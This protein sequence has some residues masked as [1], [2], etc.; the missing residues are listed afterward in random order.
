MVFEIKNH[1]IF[2]LLLG[3]ENCAGLGQIKL[4]K[5]IHGI[6]NS[7]QKLNFRRNEFEDINLCWKN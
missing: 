3:L 4:T 2:C 5:T 1:N 6:Q 7:V